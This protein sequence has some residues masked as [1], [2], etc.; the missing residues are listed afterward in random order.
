MMALFLNRIQATHWIIPT[1]EWMERPARSCEEVHSER[2]KLRADENDREDTL[3]TDD[4]AIL[5][6]YHE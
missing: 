4:K 5:G 2:A 1:E 6:T 3:T